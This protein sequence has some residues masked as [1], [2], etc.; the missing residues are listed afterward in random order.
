VVVYETARDARWLILEPYEPV[1]THRGDEVFEPSREVMAKHFTL[2][3][4]YNL[5][6][7]WE[8]TLTEYLCKYLEPGDQVEVYSCLA[9]EETLIRTGEERIVDLEDVIQGRY[10]LQRMRLPP[11]IPFTHYLAPS[12][13]QVQYQIGPVELIDHVA[14]VVKELEQIT[15]VLHK[16]QEQG[17]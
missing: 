6:V 7:G 4:I 16:A 12:V 10:E 13:P 9:G 1:I 14:R 5:H 17:F 11:E 15:V 2:P 3:H 8:E